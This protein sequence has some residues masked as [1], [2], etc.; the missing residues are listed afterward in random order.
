ME[1][2]DYIKAYKL[3]RKELRRVPPSGELISYDWPALPQNIPGQWMMYFE[4]LR[5]HARELAN[6]LNQFSTYL[7]M[8][9]A[10]DRVLGGYEEEESFYFAHEFV[11]PISTICL[12]LPYVIRSRFIFSVAHLSHQANMAL[13]PG[14]KDNLP[15]DEEIDFS[16]ADRVAGNWRAYNKLKRSLERLGGKS[17]QTEVSNFRNRYQHRYPPNIHFGLSESVRR[18]ISETGRVS[19]AIGYTKP[20]QIA[21]I[22]SSLKTQHSIAVACHKR[23][24][25][26]ID[27]H[28]DRILSP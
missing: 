4:M 6:I 19:Y 26:L 21:S 23:Y 20:V 22:V 10:W 16:T 24:Q 13:L 8:L 17:H 3:F 28:I 11:N 14:W 7:N 5:E 2:E 27:E 12:N 15:S 25:E 9:T 1:D 18:Q